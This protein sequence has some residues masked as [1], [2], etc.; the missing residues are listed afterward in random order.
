MII[1]CPVC[2]SRFNVDPARI[3]PNGQK[4]KCAKCDHIW[5]V[6]PD[7]QPAPAEESPAP[8]GLSAREIL[9]QHE[10]EAAKAQA[11]PAPAAPADV[12]PVPQ[13]PAAATP[14]AAPGPSLNLGAGGLFARKPDAGIEEPPAKPAPP[15]APAAEPTE[16][17]EP[18]ESGE[19]A[20]DPVSPAEQEETSEVEAAPQDTAPAEPE[21]ADT[22]DNPEEPDKEEAAEE[23][24]EAA[25]GKKAES[26]KPTLDPEQRKKLLPKHK[27]KSKVFVLVLLLALSLVSLLL[28][29]RYKS[30]ENQQ[31][32]EVPAPAGDE[33]PAAEP[34]PEAENQ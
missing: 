18:A 25:A 7:G 28:F 31:V 3:G 24:G 22:A 27:K 5:R 29:V 14:P 1:S 15:A 12:T 11:E 30:I 21:T 13:P 19:V 32:P 2:Q 17:A 9:A 4:L 20:E 23:N 16:T 10:A 33:A 26:R 34:P 8:A 6:A